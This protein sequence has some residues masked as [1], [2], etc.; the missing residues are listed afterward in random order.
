[1]AKKISKRRG[2]IRKANHGARPASGGKK[3]NLRG[4]GKK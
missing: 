3:V 1:M 4:A 2:R